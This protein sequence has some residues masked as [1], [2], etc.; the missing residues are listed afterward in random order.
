MLLAGSKNVSTVDIYAY[1]D[2]FV[3]WTIKI[4][5]YKLSERRAQTFVGFSYS[6]ADEIQMYFAV[7]A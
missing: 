2:I 7:C 3:A 6:Q 4:G 5:R 1:Q